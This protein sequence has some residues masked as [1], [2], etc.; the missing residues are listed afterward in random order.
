MENYCHT[1]INT[2]WSCKSGNIKYEEILKNKNI[3]AKYFIE[4]RKRRMLK[5][6]QKSIGR[7][8][9]NWKHQQL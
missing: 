3:R 2:T 7:D 8:Q 9:I 4:M 6:L 5:I 1:D